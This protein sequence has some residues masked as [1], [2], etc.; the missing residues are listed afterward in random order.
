[1]CA[2][3]VRR[4]TKSCR[5]IGTTGV[6]MDDIMNWTSQRS[7]LSYLER[8]KGK[9]HRRRRKIN[10][11]KSTNLCNERNASTPR[12]GNK[13]CQTSLGTQIVT[14]E[15]AKRSQ[16]SSGPFANHEGLAAGKD[17][18]ANVFNGDSSLV[19]VIFPSPTNE[20]LSRFSPGTSRGIIAM[21]TKPS[22]LVRRKCKQTRGGGTST[23]S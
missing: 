2:E 20:L 3:N 13:K 18:A 5:F 16:I 23:P 14:A 15:I 7:T 12:D 19:S 8:G 9:E 4:V 10:G 22:G 17:S 21:E 6:K 1:M 11:I